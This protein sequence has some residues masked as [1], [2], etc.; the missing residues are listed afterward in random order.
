MASSIFLTA[1]H[2][3]VLTGPGVYPAPGGT[4]FVGSGVSPDIGVKTGHTLFSILQHTIS[5]GGDLR[6]YSA[7]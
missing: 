6:T 2:A 7:P 3:D 5:F 4:T 1:V